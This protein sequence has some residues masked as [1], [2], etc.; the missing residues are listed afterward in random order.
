MVGSDTPSNALAAHGPSHDRLML[1]L[2]EY[3]GHRLL[4]IRRWYFPA[5]SREWRPTQKGISLTR[6]AYE[7]VLK[8]IQ[9]DE[10][11]IQRHFAGSDDT[12]LRAAAAQEQQANC[13]QK[14]RFGSRDFEIETGSWSGQDFFRLEGRGAT[15]VLCINERHPVGK[16]LLQDGPPAFIA[17]MLIALGRACRL[18]DG[19]ADGQR[20]EALE[21]LMANWGFV[22]RQYLQEATR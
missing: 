1:V 19:G 17:T 8:T 20:A 12:H 6:D 18:M 11:K 2:A 16:A 15:D 21:L 5:G 7:F 4:D 10:T 14:A 22:L 13:A 3:K 9:Q